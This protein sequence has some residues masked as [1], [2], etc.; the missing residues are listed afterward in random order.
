MPFLTTYTLKWKNLKLGKK[1]SNKYC[2]EL[3]L[4]KKCPTLFPMDLEIQ[5]IHFRRMFCIY[6]MSI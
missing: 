3:Q 4:A 6:S 5:S 2:I 1:E